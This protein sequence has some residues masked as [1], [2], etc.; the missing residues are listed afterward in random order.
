MTGKALAHDVT[1]IHPGQVGHCE[2]KRILEGEELHRT[3]G[4]AVTQG[5]VQYRLIC[6]FTIFANF[7]LLDRTEGEHGFDGILFTPGYKPHEQNHPRR[8]KMFPFHL[9]LL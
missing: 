9:V 4:R 6:Y 2:A 8:V 7:D 3:K 1:R 5:K